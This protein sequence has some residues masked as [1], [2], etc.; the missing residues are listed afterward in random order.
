MR[1]AG[2]LYNELIREI[3]IVAECLS[4]YLEKI[5]EILS[6]AGKE[7][8]LFFLY[9]IRKLKTVSGS[10]AVHFWSSSA[11]F[12]DETLLGDWLRRARR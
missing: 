9:S 8:Y 12:Q 3:E 2:A 11:R 5:R 7:K 6:T 4:I 10:D 1:A